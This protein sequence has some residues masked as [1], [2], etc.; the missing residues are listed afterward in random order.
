MAT[1][2]RNIP[3]PKPLSLT[4]NVGQNWKTFKR[5]FTNYEVAT[6]LNKENMEIRVATLLSCIGS[7]A[8]DIYDGF[9]MSEEQRKQIPD[10]LRAFENY[11]I[12]ET[13]ETYERYV[14]N[15]RNQQEGESVEKYIAELRRLAKS[16]NFDTLEDNL[17]RDRVV[18]GVRCDI[19][20][21]KLLQEGKL[22]LQKA[23]TI[24]RAM[25]VTK[26]Q[27][28][29]IKKGGE[30]T[31]ELVHKVHKNVPQKKN[32]EKNCHFCGKAHI[33]KKELCPAYGKTCNACKGKNHFAG[34]KFCR[35][36]IRVVTDYDHDQSDALEDEDDIWLSAVGNGRPRATATLNVNGKDIQFQLD[37]GS[38]VNTICQR[39]VRKQ[40]V[41]RT[42]QRLTMW[43]K[44]KVEPIGEVSLETMNPKTGTSH[45]ITYTVV[46]NSLSCLLGMETVKTLGFITLNETKYI[47]KIDE[48]SALGDPESTTTTNKHSSLGDLGE[49]HLHIDTS[50]KPKQLPCRRVPFA[51]Q[52]KVKSQISALV[53][54]GVLT[55]E[56]EP[57][58]W[59]SQMA[60]AEK[61]NGDIR[62]C[63]DPAPLNEAL[64]REH[65]KL[66]TLDDVL[67]QLNGARLFTKLDVKEAYWHVRLD[68][69]SSKL[70]TMITPFGRYRW[71]RLPFG[72]KVSGEIFQR[73]IA[74]ALDGLVGTTNVADD[75]I[76]AGRGKDVEEAR[77]NLKQN[78]QQLKQR[79]K[80]KHI[81]LN[82]AK[83]VAEEP[84]IT[85]MG[86]TITENG[87]APDPAKVTAIKNMPAPMDISA[88]RRLCGTVQY[89]A[90]FIPNLAQH[91]E[92]MRVLTR[93]NAEWNWTTECQQ[94]FNKIKNIITEDALLA[95]F[96]MDKELF[97]QVDS[98]Q[99]GVG[100]FL[101]QDGRPIEYASK[102]LTETQR[103]WAQ[104]EKEL[105]SVVI[106]L[107]RFD[108]YTYG[109]KV[110]VQNDHKPLEQ[111]I[112]KTLSQVPRRLQNLLMRLHRYDITF[113]YVEGPKLHVADT[114]SR[115]VAENEVH[116][117]PDLQIHIISG[118]AD[119][120]MDKFRE[121]TKADEILQRLICCIRDGWQEDED[122]TSSVI[123]F[124]PIK[125]TLSVEDDIIYKG[126]QIIV[127]K[128]LRA[129]VKRKLHAAHLGYDSMMRR[130]RG[131]IY[132]PGMKDEIKQL[133]D[134]CDTCQRRKPANQKE[135]LNQHEEGGA[136]WERVGIDFF[137][138]KEHSYI[139]IVD[140]LSTY[141]EVEYMSSTTS[142]QTIK[143]LKK[144]FSRWGIPKELVSD[145]GPQLVSQEFED[146]LR[147]WGI[148]HN[149]SDPLY[150]K[151]NGKAEAAVKTIKNML[152]KCH[153]NG[154]DPYVALLE[155]RATPRQDVNMSPA[156]L[157]LGRQP[158]TFIPTKTTA[159]I[160]NKYQNLREKRRESIKKC[161]DKGA[162]ALTEIEAEHPVY[163]KD[164]QNK[165]C[166]GK[167]T[168]RNER[169]YQVL[170]ENGGEYTRNRF[171][172]RPKA[173]PFDETFEA[174]MYTP[175]DQ[176]VS[177]A[178]TNERRPVRERRAP[179]WHNDYVQP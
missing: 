41:K 13:N 7:N 145:N 37:T 112:K 66:P 97:L 8:M 56:T 25:E 173:T 34:T 92:P 168:G 22:T 76:V 123:A 18:M 166:P 21:R 131:T 40:Q 10:I 108:Q 169:K 42:S 70:T 153:E 88:V 69:E 160:S 9:P 106:G 133:A 90:R 158:R 171:H 114:L 16:C 49:A 38:D 107:E 82:D 126:E 67:S 12:G 75:I 50:K 103:R 136:P 177:Q 99:S 162:K 132:W 137:D 150:P 152:L 33:F 73:R 65:Y 19:T 64:M 95:Y 116:E 151:G 159:K 93:K 143:T 155:L 58:E 77:D 55:P 30:G 134:T 26:G 36:D 167:V 45:E 44:T 138:I 141:I 57:T 2:G 110:I 118:V 68:E 172:I 23:T 135:P 157:M 4:G 105:L 165:W 176:D 121:A 179:L 80:E 109:R 51:L 29:R 144:T 174:A 5:D 149:P 15:S 130:A 43:N 27:M 115:A 148:K 128:S 78:A 163:Y 11:C 101:H 147:S 161:Y 14:F 74:E 139:V 119:T 104:I 59:V 53:E 117:I 62:I 129:E 31:E 46:P 146:F 72:L 91:L 84:K 63:I 3:I 98:S 89:L 124:K 86:H 85:F 113:Q 111:I 60:L 79:C 71:L 39:Y 48:N 102:T 164:A 83:E 1:G 127:P 28:T 47:A 35:A 178:D 96:D 87:I 6:K 94:S 32:P 52:A 61:S 156:E 100:C 122:Q 20:R 120:M 140:Y 54:R 81:L 175:R 24:A 125:D 170:G 142:Q 17:I 154:D